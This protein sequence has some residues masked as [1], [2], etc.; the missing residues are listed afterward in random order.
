METFAFFVW[1]MMA[2]LQTTDGIISTSCVETCVGQ[3]NENYQHCTDCHS[4]VACSNGYKYVMPCPSNLVWDDVK[5]R[6]E[7]TSATCNVTSP[8]RNILIPTRQEF[9][10][11]LHIESCVRQRDGNYQHC[12][13]CHKYVACSNERDYIMPCPSNLVWHDANKTC[14]WTSSTCNSTTHRY[15]VTSITSECAESCGGR[16]DGHYQHCSDCHQYVACNNYYKYELPCDFKLVWDDIKKR[17]ETTSSTCNETTTETKAMLID[18]DSGCVNSC[19]GHRDGNYQ[20]CSDCHRYVACINGHDY[21]M[22]CPSNLVWDDKIKG[23]EVTSATCNLTTHESTT[24]KP[25]PRLS[26]CVENCFDR[27]DGNYQYC[28]DCSHYVECKNGF[29]YI[30]PC[31]FNLVWDD[32]NKICN[33]TSSTCL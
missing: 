9:S 28:L 15:N 12:S 4:Y 20:H 10:S 27:T 23:C 31:H 3:S 8:L 29:E 32:G 21:S 1:I 14:E 30:R 2:T 22:P 19:V 24:T 16:G 11:Y 13:N 18:S 7:Y 6:C 26:G 33:W 25:F 5:K 17:C